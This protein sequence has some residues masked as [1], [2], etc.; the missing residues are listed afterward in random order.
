MQRLMLH[1]WPGNI[2]ELANMVERAVVLAFHDIITADL[3]LLGGEVSQIPSRQLVSLTE[4]QEEA[5]RTYLIQ[6]LTATR[7]NISQAAALAGRYRPDLYK[8]L[9]KHALD[10]AA[11]KDDRTTK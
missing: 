7:G 10:P 3:L 4:A 8:L 9:R 1:D 6:V 11:F 2:R 5:E